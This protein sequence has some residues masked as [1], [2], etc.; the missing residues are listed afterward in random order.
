MNPGRSF[1][2]MHHRASSAS[3]VLVRD[4][5]NEQTTQH[6][7]SLAELTQR[8]ERHTRLS[9]EAVEQLQKVMDA[10][11]DELLREKLRD[12]RET[13]LL[14]PDERL[15]TQGTARQIVHEQIERANE[16]AREEL[17]A[18]RRYETGGTLT[19]LR[20]DETYER[21]RGRG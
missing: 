17:R 1:S 8:L 12:E 16:K 13:E 15:I 18:R 10:R 5:L 9:A 20:E 7:R 3:T 19:R 21:M 11:F 4:R 14:R 6:R 2:L